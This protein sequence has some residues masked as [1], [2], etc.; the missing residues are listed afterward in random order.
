ML[1]KKHGS[2]DQSSGD[3]F[4]LN[5]IEYIENGKITESMIIIVRN[6]GIMFPQWFVVA[7]PEGN[8][9]VCNKLE[10]VCQRKSSSTS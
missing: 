4:I 6:K 9:N 3:L 1:S 2:A 8:M 7:P 5:Y 10:A